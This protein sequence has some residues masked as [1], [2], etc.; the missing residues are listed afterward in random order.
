MVDVPGS[1]PEAPKPLDLRRPVVRVMR[2]AAQVPVVQPNGHLLE[3]DPD[4]A[5]HAPSLIPGGKQCILR[6]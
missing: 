1:V 5:P 2:V 6:R 4:P 3:E